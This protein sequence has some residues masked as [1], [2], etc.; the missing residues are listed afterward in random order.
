MPTKMAPEHADW[1][2]KSQFLMA[3]ATDID[4]R[5]PVYIGQ[6]ARE[7][8][9]RACKCVCPAC[10]GELEAVNAGRPEEHFARPRALR[11]HFRHIAGHQ[12]DGCLTYAANLA[13]LHL[14]VEQGVIELPRRL[15]SGHVQGLSGQQYTAQAEWP[16][17]TRKVVHREWMD[18]HAARV[19]TD[20]GR[21]IVIHLHGRFGPA[22]G[23]SADAVIAVDVSD[24]EV[25]AWSPDNIL[26]RARLTPGWLCWERHGADED[27]QLQADAKA[28][29]AAIDALDLVPEGFEI[30]EGLTALQRSETLLH[31]HLKRILASA[32]GISVP[33]LTD[34][35]ELA[36]P[37]GSVGRR[38]I[39]LP[40]TLM[41]MA[42]AK[43]EHRIA[44]LVADIVCQASDSA[45]SFAVDDMLIEVAVTHYVD[46]AKR[47]RIADANL[48][49]LELDA[50]LISTSGSRLTLQQLRSIVIDHAHSKRWINHPG[51]ARCRRQAEHD[52]HARADSMRNQLLLHDREKQKFGQLDDDAALDLF[53]DRRR[54]RDGDPRDDLR[55]VTLSALSLPDLALLL[56][57]RGFGK[58][59]ADEISGP[60]G[61]FGALE[62][63]AEASR[64]ENL[65]DRPFRTFLAFFEG[66]AERK[67]WCSLLLAAM[68]VFG[69]REPP[70]LEQ[71]LKRCREAVKQSLRNAELTFARPTQWDKAIAVRF[72][73]LERHI[74]SGHCTVAHIEDKQRARRKAEGERQQ[75]RQ[76][77]REAL[78]AKAMEDGRAHDLQRAIEHYGQQYQWA[79]LGGLPV[80][81]AAAHRLLTTAGHPRPSRSELD[82]LAS[83]WA[84]REHDTPVKVW[85]QSTRC[86]TEAEVTHILHLA[87]AA[88]LLDET[89]RSARR[90]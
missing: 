47:R 90:R 23:G 26:A 3:W 8:T 30:P 74:A 66:H 65:S 56:E 77:E 40:P 10:D 72:P 28:G 1:V 22:R 5:R 64:E 89:N 78:R 50:R 2:A 31:L 61:V 29:E 39:H 86:R 85:L 63:I 12:R 35:V 88:Y 53:F 18:T 67:R 69:L 27:L 38:S 62:A 34:Q 6:L 32:D 11:P 71:R 21:V 70:Y 41:T 49:C 16:G 51:L 80:D 15:V 57:E 44:G 43:V 36:M 75:A 83:A 52:L 42:N 7:R 17:E 81:L 14:L 68:G 45:G 20:D 9:G 79:P 46:D 54:A 58:L 73:E 24:P 19:V 48:P 25:A 76:Q 13:A 33:G 82:A 4:S 87:R 59:G 60:W 84:A 37:D 55:P